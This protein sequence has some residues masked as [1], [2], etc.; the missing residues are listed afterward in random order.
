MQRPFL[1]RRGRLRLAILAAV[2]G[3]IASLLTCGSCVV[4]R[5]PEAM[6]QAK[7]WR[8]AAE[9]HNADVRITVDCGAHTY[10]GSGVV[11]SP[12]RVL[13]ALHVVTCDGAGDNPLPLISIYE[14]DGSAVM[15]MIEVA[16]PERDIARLW[17][18]TDAFKAEATPIV[19][20]PV[21]TVGD[22]VCIAAAMPNWG[23]HCYD[24]QPPE[25][26]DKDFHIASSVIELGNSGAGVY[27][28]QGRLVG[29]FVTA[30]E[31][32][33]YLCVGGVSPLAEDPW[34]IPGK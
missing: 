15:Y 28:A 12:T 16:L 7:V 33:Q 17:T 5:V 10:G 4:L 13:T 2:A 9:Q 31:C 14:G 20:G 34:L 24:V 6:H 18:F 21:P 29:I 30:R 19:V 11:V 3:A 25:P 22:R 23:Y 27:D 26:N 1:P 32:S 8:N